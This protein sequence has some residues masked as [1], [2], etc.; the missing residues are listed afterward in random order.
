MISGRGSEE[1]GA[2]TPWLGEGLGEK[3]GTLEKLALEVGLER[4][5]G[6]VDIAREGRG[7]AISG[8]QITMG[9]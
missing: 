1:H 8:L 3:S 7:L 9:S 4:Q 6:S 2:V 5:H